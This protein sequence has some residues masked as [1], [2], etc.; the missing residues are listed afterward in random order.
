MKILFTYLI[1]VLLM[2]IGCKKRLIDYR[3]K[4]CGTWEFN[5]Q[6]QYCGQ[7][8]CQPVTQGFENC[9]IYYLKRG[10]REVV[11]FNFQTIDTVYTVE[12]NGSFS[13]CGSSGKF[14]SKNKMHFTYS[15]SSCHGGMGGTHY[16]TVTATKK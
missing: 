6:Y 11:Y 10:P 14:D 3:N 2:T 4:Y 13:G 5:Y 1:V 12:R 15:S 16:Y 8:V 9:K 7:G